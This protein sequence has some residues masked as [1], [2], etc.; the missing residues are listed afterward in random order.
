[1]PHPT[2]CSYQPASE[3]AVE[4]D[5]RRSLEFLEQW[6]LLDSAQQGFALLRF[7]ADHSFLPVAGK[8]WCVDT[9]LPT[10][11]TSPTREISLPDGRNSSVFDEIRAKLGGGK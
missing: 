9:L 10:T 7:G 3:D 8:S 1:M 2:R 5:T 4:R 11:A 6:S